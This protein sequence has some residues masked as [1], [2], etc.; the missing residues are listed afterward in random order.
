MFDGYSD[1]ENLLFLYCRRRTVGLH[2]EMYTLRHRSV[3]KS[4]T[5]G[6]VDGL[7]E[8]QHWDRGTVGTIDFDRNPY[9]DHNV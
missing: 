2:W 4:V 9:T 8:A 6:S 7:A 5:E 1:G 3:S